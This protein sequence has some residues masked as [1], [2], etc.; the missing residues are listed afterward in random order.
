M[1][2]LPV[3]KW[4]SPSV[5]VRVLGVD[6]T[7][8]VWQAGN[9]LTLDRNAS[10]NAPRFV[11]VEL[12][13]S[14]VLVR[15]LDLTGVPAS[16]VPQ[17]VALEAQT[18]SPFVSSDLLWGYGRSSSSEG[19][20]QF[21][22]VLAS[23]KK[24]HAFMQ[25]HLTQIQGNTVPEVWVIQGL[26]EP[27]VLSGFGEGLRIRRQV[28][29]SRA[30]FG[31]LFTAIALFVAICATPSLQLYIR[32]VDA[33]KAFTVER[34]STKALAE[35]RASYL[36]SLEQLHELAQLTANRVD[37]LVVMDQLTR[38]IPDD[39]NVLSLQVN[40]TKV[41]IAG[42]TS[43][44]ANLMQ[45]LGAQAGVADVKAPAAATRALGLSKD[46]YTIEFSLASPLAPVVQPT[47]AVSSV[48]A[49]ASAPATSASSGTSTPA[50]SK[51][52]PTTS[53]RMP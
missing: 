27:V 3:F 39:T 44:A 30:V 5:L 38:I 36:A 52:E 51:P 53:M 1:F 15:N 29:A 28:L 25:E 2:Q 23:S 32:S 49:L 24:V 47:N 26:V 16:E 42:Q 13:E 22:V 45:Y 20:D 48:A 4:L 10:V 41:A 35:K 7:P 37:P 34:Q 31:M 18:C 11:A 17:A 43:N 14:H 46:S 19:K 9:T 8:S 21:T 40:G 33:V 12:P 6:G 50:T